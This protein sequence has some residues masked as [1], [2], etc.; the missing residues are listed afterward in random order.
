VLRS[1]VEYGIRQSIVIT[2][3]DT[4]EPP[5]ENGEFPGVSGVRELV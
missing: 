3:P 2:H 5:R 1:A 4:T